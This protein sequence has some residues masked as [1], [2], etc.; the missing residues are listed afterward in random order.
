M[1][2]LGVRVTKPEEVKPAL[3]RLLESGKPGVLEISISPP[4]L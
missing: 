3:A 4:P 2:A 1:G